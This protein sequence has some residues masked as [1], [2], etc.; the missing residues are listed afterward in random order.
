MKCPQCKQKTRI[1]QTDQKVSGLTW[2]RRICL[3]CA[4][5]FSTWEGDDGVE[6]MRPPTETESVRARGK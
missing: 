6:R 2:R 1:I 4:H 5:I 3:S